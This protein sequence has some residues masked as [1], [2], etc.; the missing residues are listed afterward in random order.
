MTLTA[1]AFQSLMTDGSAAGCAATARLSDVDA[2]ASAAAR[3][4]DVGTRASA[5][6]PPRPA[7][8]ERR[9]TSGPP[10]SPRARSDVTFGPRDDVGR[11][12]AAHMAP[13]PSGV[14]EQAMRIPTMRAVTPS[15]GPR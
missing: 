2:R 15:H 5:V 7:R 3:L 14:A 13:S 1:V 8:N 11:R 10:S 12:I 9:E 6:A 4:A